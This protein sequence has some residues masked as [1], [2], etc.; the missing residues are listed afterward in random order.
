MIREYLRESIRESGYSRISV[1]DIAKGLGL[2]KKT[3]YRHYDSKESMYEDLFNYEL[4]AAYNSLIIL[5]QEKGPMAEKVNKLSKII[6]K[7]LILFNIGSLQNIK[8]EYYGLWKEIV[9]FR[10]NR[11]YP[12]IDLLI[13]HS[14]K[15]GLLEEYPNELIIELFSTSLN[16]AIE[17]NS[18]FEVGQKYK[19][20]FNSIFEILLNG[21]LTKKGKKL[22]AINKRMKYESN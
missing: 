6:E 3:I 10:K 19:E 18:S 7:N 14:R 16:L 8:R 15:N 17:R 9:L 21:I 11:V 12:L 1:S 13:D 4:E 22:L 5:I 2:S 20:V